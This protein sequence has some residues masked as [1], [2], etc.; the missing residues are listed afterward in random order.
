MDSAGATA[1]GSAVNDSSV[2]GGAGGA[3]AG[4]AGSGE[5]ASGAAP[6]SAAATASSKPAFQASPDD[7]P[8]QVVHNQD[9]ILNFIFGGQRGAFIGA[10]VATGAPPSPDSVD[11]RTCVPHVRLLPFNQEI[12]PRHQMKARSLH[13]AKVRC[14]VTRVLRWVSASCNCRRAVVVFTCR[15]S[16][17]ME[18]AAVAKAKTD[19]EGA[20]RD[21]NEVIALEPQYSS[22]YNNRYRRSCHRVCWARDGAHTPCSWSC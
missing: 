5:P 20:L 21:L 12:A 16:A 7:A 8:F 11:V 1:D 2:P 18:R 15:A 17:E 3:G 14:C 10:D 4:T 6:V 13:G 19:L 22:A 9:A